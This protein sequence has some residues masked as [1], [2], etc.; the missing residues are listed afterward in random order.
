M[1]ITHHPSEGVLA[2]FANAVLDEAAALVVAAHIAQCPQCRAAVRRYE[3]I[4][5]SL[6]EMTEASAPMT[7]DAGELLSRSDLVPESPPSPVYVE[8]DPRDRSAAR[9]DRLMSLYGGSKWRWIGPGVHWQPM[10][11]PSDADIRVFLLKARPGTALP[12]HR[13]SGIEWTCVLQ[14]AFSHAHGRFGQG[15]FDEADPSVEHEPV[16]EAGEECICLVAMNGRLELQGL[17]GRMLQ[18]FVRL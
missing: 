2:E 14:G 13:H 9:L 10:A 11:V 3:L 1:T 8:H 7:A 18:P 5:G 16:V 17:I 15:D 4:G 12:H 6:L